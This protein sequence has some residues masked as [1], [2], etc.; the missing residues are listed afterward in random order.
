[1]RSLTPL[2][3]RFAA[4]PARD[5]PVASARCSE[6]AA[7][8]RV[9]M[10]W[11][12]TQIE[13]TSVLLV[14]LARLAN[15]PPAPAANQRSRT[16]PGSQVWYWSDSCAGRPP[17]IAGRSQTPAAGLIDLPERSAIAEARCCTTGA[18]ILSWRPVVPAR[19]RDPAAARPVRHVRVTIAFFQREGDELARH[20]I[21]RDGSVVHL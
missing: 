20:V 19:R 2:F 18:G 13:G 11:S 1:M 21:K 16:S 10:V 4:V 12:S 9:S 6:A 14:K 5:Y 3:L 8:R 15:A 17:D 7:V